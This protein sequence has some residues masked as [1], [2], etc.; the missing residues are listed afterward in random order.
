M[1][2]RFWSLA[3]AAFGTAT[4]SGVVDVG[5]VRRRG[6]FLPLFMSTALIVGPIWWSDAGLVSPL[7]MTVTG[8]LDPEPP[9]C[10]EATRFEPFRGMLRGRMW[11]WSATGWTTV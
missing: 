10:G 9:E 11:Y 1:I 2:P 3:A 4:G 5:D 6:L 7:R 8:V